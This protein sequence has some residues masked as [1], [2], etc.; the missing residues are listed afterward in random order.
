MVAIEN[1]A[2]NKLN[3]PNSESNNGIARTGNDATAK[4]ITVLSL[5]AL[6]YFSDLKSF[7]GYNLS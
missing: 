7:I 4:K 1:N 6:L 5:P 3:I 2:W